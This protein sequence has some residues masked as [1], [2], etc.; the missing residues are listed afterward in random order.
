[1]RFFFHVYD[2]DLKFSS[3]YKEFRF[4]LVSNHCE[5][6]WSSTEIVFPFEKKNIYISYLLLYHLYSNCRI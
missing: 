3:L 5:M 2:C 6:L 1:M 4:C